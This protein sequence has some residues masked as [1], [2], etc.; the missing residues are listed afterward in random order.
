LEPDHLR[1]VFPAVTAE[2]LR[3][4][5]SAA[6]FLARLVSYGRDK[7]WLTAKAAE[8]RHQAARQE[9]RPWRDAGSD[10]VEPRPDERPRRNYGR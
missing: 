8:L 5:A 10:D 1:V 2:E 9:Q 4:E 3:K 7:E 6:E